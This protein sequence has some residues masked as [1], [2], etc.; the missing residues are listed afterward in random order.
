M[1]KIK[2]NMMTLPTGT[3]AENAKRTKNIILLVY[4]HSIMIGLH[5]ITPKRKIK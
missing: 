3:L 5:E 1:L 2:N 4:S